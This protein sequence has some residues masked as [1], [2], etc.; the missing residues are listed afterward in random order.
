MKR[1]TFYI[2][3][4]II[5]TICFIAAMCEAQTLPV[6]W[7]VTGTFTNPTIVI[8]QDA[9]N[10]VI[11]IGTNQKAVA[12]TAF[13]K[14]TSPP[15]IVHDTVKVVLDPKQSSDYIELAKQFTEAIA[16]RDYERLQK[17][18]ALSDYTQ[19][20]AQYAEAVRMMKILK[21]ELRKD[22]IIQVRL[23]REMLITLPVR[24]P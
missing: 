20:Q 15:V 3:T 19:A 17:E 18:E 16:E 13:T 4:V 22:T 12:K 14:L 9:N 24:K 7:N 5:I 10:L 11:R 2:A 1:F 8:T 21:A 23:S 6:N